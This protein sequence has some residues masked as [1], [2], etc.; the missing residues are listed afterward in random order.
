MSIVKNMNTHCTIELSATTY[1]DKVELN[2]T[3]YRGCKIATYE[4]FRSKQG[5]TTQVFIGSVEEGQL[6]FTDSSIVCPSLFSYRVLGTSICGRQL[7]SFSDT[8]IAGPIDN[9]F[10]GQ[11]V[12]ITRST[13]QES[14][15]ILTEWAP[16]LIA[17][18]YVA[19]YKIFRAED[20]GTYLPIDS[21]GPY[22]TSYVDQYVN[23]DE[24][25][26]QYKI[27]VKNICEIVNTPGAPGTSILLQSDIIEDQPVLFWTPYDKW[28]SGVH[29]YEIER[30]NADGEWEVIK[31]V[32]PG[33]KII[34]IKQ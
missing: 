34:I 20:E 12:D 23:I 22:T 25:S 30:K 14:S 3:P 26:Y 16:P 10:I 2:W 15:F 29:H 13:V 33:E 27:E 17:P 19:Q 4:I 21:V 18:L 5:A 31:K 6:S 32:G 8:V 11:V 28:D 9:Q 24:A 7:G 1:S